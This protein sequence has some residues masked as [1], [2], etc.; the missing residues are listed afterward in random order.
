MYLFKLQTSYNSLKNHAFK[1]GNNLLPGF[2]YKNKA[3]PL[4]AGSESNEKVPRQT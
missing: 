3:I 2:R 4:Y 1:P